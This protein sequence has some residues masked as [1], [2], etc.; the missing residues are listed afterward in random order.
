[1]GFSGE[2]S[3]GSGGLVIGILFGS[4]T[5]QP[6][7]SGEPSS[8]STCGMFAFLPKNSR[9]GPGFVGVPNSPLGTAQSGIAQSLISFG[10]RTVPGNP[11]N[12][13]SSVAGSRM[14]RA[15]F[16]GAIVPNL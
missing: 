1:P 15:A 4:L 13:C 2:P 16:S 12:D 7:F 6:G 11:C 3:S 14:N 5:I 10:A 9:N 8:G